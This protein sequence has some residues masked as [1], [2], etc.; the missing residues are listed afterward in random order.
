MS[1]IE[2]PAPEAAAG[3]EASA[4]TRALDLVLLAAP[5]VL[6]AVFFRDLWYAAQAFSLE[7]A[8]NLDLVY[9]L[10]DRFFA[11]LKQ[12]RLA[13]WNPF[14]WGGMPLV[15]NPNFA[16]S[17]LHLLAGWWLD[18]GG[19]IWF[20]SVFSFLELLAAFYGFYVL[21]RM[22]WP[23]RPVL[24]LWAATL[25]L[26]SGGV[27]TAYVFFSTSFHFAAIPWTLLLLARVSR[28]TLPRTVGWLALLL[29]VQLTWGQLQFTLYS[30]YLYAGFALFAAG[31]GRRL[32]GVG[33]LC[34]GGAVAGLLSAAHLIPL[35]ESLRIAAVDE[36]RLSVPFHP[37]HQRVPLFYALRLLYPSLIGGVFPE[38]LALRET[39][40]IPWWP[41]WRDGWSLWESFTAYQGIVVTVTAAFGVLFGPSRLFWKLPYVAIPLAT[42]TTAGVG[43]LYYVHLGMSVPY[44]RLTV[45]L[46]L[47]ATVLCVD[48]ALALLRSRRLCW[49]YAAFLAGVLAL[50]TAWNASPL[51]GRVVERGFAEA[52]QRPGP[53]IAQ[54]LPAMRQNIT[55]HNVFL[56][57]ALLA[58]ATYLLLT[59]RPS[60]A[61]GLRA[62]WLPRGFVLALAL[63]ASA[64]GTAFL[65]RGRQVSVTTLDTLGIF[66]PSPLE[67]ALRADAPDWMAHRLHLDIPFFFHRGAVALRRTRASPAGVENA[68]RLLPNGTMLAGIPITT[69]YTSLVADNR[70]MTDLF[71]WER[72]V[73]YMFRTLESHAT[74]HPGLVDI[75]A[76]RY[77]LRHRGWDYA[78]RRTDVSD[79]EGCGGWFDAH[80]RVLAEQDG[81]VL[82]RL[83]RALPRF[84]VP[85]RVVWTQ[86]TL[87]A[88]SE[89][90]CRRYGKETLGVL[91]ADG[92][93]R[94][95]RQSGRVT[96]VEIPRG[97]EVRLRVEAA[98][99][100][101]VIL[102][103]HR[104]PWWEARVDGRPAPLLRANSVFMA[105]EVPP[106][107]HVV[108]LRC[109]ARS[110]T[111][112]LWVS[113]LSLAGFAVLYASRGLTR[114]RHRLR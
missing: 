14:L 80:A 91:N 7:S 5:L 36:P 26:F 84:H 98:T 35:L 55:N 94:E 81:F 100:V 42:T 6:L 22:L 66:R 112:G 38:A 43:L 97:E 111:V 62:R 18:R 31:R 53:F 41:I 90:G 74:L 68:F 60:S 30:L 99:P 70:A 24:A 71:F 34:A 78:Y 92:P 105:V 20:M 44:G 75:F 59:R 82:Y 33:A 23:G 12:G 73:G 58:V 56:A 47:F 61:D 89:G 3:R 28:P 11:E 95:T 4:G 1:P 48:T 54:Y 49:G 13:V 40:G 69:G 113:G 65:E 77:V 52:Y 29:W 64:D 79:P 21:G 67:R 50:S 76:I 32:L 104:H 114:L 86:E 85:E 93:R 106:G 15:G 39:P 63:L 8:D 109:R 110:L 87:G 51:V 46:S 107:P 108:E 45:L 10:F 83:D 103:I 9:P 16:L 37:A 25:Y 96:E 101:H 2:A 72:G 57:V 19:F 102:G 17:P 27:F 88:F